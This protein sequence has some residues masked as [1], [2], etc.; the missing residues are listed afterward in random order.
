MAARCPLDKVLLVNAILTT[1][2]LR[3]ARHQVGNQVDNQ[4]ANQ[5]GNQV[6][7]H[8]D[9]QVDNQVGNHVGN[10]VDNPNNIRVT[11]CPL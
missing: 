11:R 7:N 10:Q 3:I 4:V 2:E 8:E 6:D 5:V 9:N 1:D